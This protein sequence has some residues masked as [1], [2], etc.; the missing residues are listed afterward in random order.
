[1]LF[2]EKINRILLVLFSVLAGISYCQID[3]QEDSRFYD[4]ELLKEPVQQA[5]DRAPFNV[6]VGN[7]SD[8]IDPLF[9]YE[10]NG[11]V[12]SHHH[13]DE[14]GDI[15]HQDWQDYLNLKDICVIWGDN[16]KRETYK[17]LRFNN[18]SWTCWVEADDRASWHSFN[19]EELSNNHL[20]TDNPEVAEVIL[21]AKPGDQIRFSGVL[22]QY[23]NLKSSFKRGSSTSRADSGNGACETIYIDDFKIIKQG[24]ASW[25]GLY[26]FSKFGAY[27]TFILFLVL[28][29]ILPYRRN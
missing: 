24:N 27:F 15:Y 9:D 13:A 23:A 21:E 26:S 29:V 22:A 17:T 3:K 6:T 1:M 2:I 4:A 28:F 7:Q 8:R 5:T 20:L 11:V 14:F 16:V 12:V 18:T 10:L 19:Q 25:R